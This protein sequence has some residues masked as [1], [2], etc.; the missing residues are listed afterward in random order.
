MSTYEIVVLIVGSIL[1]AALVLAVFVM[2]LL[3]KDLVIFDHYRTTAP[4]CYRNLKS[5][6]RFNGFLVALMSVGGIIGAPFAAIDPEGGVLLAAGMV[7]VSGIF[8]WL[9]VRW[10]L[11]S[12]RA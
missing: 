1:L 2:S 11:W 5:V 3:G 4:K 6:C 8:L 7:A 10:F 12:L 9:S